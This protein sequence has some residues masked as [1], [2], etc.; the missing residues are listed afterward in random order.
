M[1]VAIKICGLTTIDAARATAEAGADYAGFVFVEKSKRF[2]TPERAKALA[3]E[4]G[5][6]VKRVSLTVDA[7]DRELEEIVAV[8]DP[9]LVQ[10]HGQESPERV[11]EIRAT[12]GKPVMKAVGVSE[13]ADLHAARAYRAVADLLLFDAKPP[14]SMPSA[15]PGG[16]GLVFDWALIAADRPS[17][18]WMLSGGLTV[19]NVAE[20]VRMSQAPAVDV[21]SG[22]EA[23]PGR[24]SPERIKAFC[25]AV[26]SVLPV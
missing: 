16:N 3:Q 5:R 12:F 13:T 18:D 6:E 23:A 15:L 7:S 22:V 1:G 8:L 11:A 26:R 25:R 20:A 21:S 19:D 17:G 2:V 24:K 4:M 14:K 10:L 9:D